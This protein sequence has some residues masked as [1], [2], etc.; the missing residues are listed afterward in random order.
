[1]GVSIGNDRRLVEPRVLPKPLRYREGV[2]LDFPPPNSFVATSMELA[3][4]DATYR[5]GEFIADLAAQRPRLCKAKMMSIGGGATAHQARLV[6]HEFA[7]VIVA[8]ADSLGRHAAATTFGVLLWNSLG[9]PCGIL[10]GAG[11]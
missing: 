7:V 10:I 8:Q 5:Y 6:G 11:Y 4:M 3:V 2:N 9:G 1:L